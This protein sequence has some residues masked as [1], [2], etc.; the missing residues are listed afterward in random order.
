MIAP[1]ILR[2][3]KVYY[4]DDCKEVEWKWTGDGCKPAKC[5]TRF[6]RND[7]SKS[8]AFVEDP[9]WQKGQSKAIRYIKA[10]LELPA[11]DLKGKEKLNR[12]LSQPHLFAF[13]VLIKAEDDEYSVKLVK[14]KQSDFIFNDLHELKKLLHCKNIPEWIKNFP[15]SMYYQFVFLEKQDKLP[16][17]L[18]ELAEIL[19]FLPN[20]SFRQFTVNFMDR[21]KKLHT[22]EQNLSFCSAIA[23]ICIKLKELCCEEVSKR[24]ALW[25]SEL[26]QKKWKEQ[27]KWIF[28]ERFEEQ[29]KL[30][31]P[32]ILGIAE[33]LLSKM[34]QSDVGLEN[35]VYLFSALNNTIEIIMTF[36]E[37]TEDKK[38]G[39]TKFLE[40][41]ESKKWKEWQ[42][43][44]FMRTE[45]KKIAPQQEQNLLFNLA[46]KNRAP[47]EWKLERI[48]TE[49]LK[50]LQDLNPFIDATLTNEYQEL[51]ENLI[52]NESFLVGNRVLRLSPS[53]NIT[54][55]L[56][57][58]AV[59][60]QREYDS[61]NIKKPLIIYICVPKGSDPKEE[62][63]NT[64]DRY[65]L[66]D[67]WN[68]IDPLKHKNF[69]WII[70]DLSKDEES[71]SVRD[72]PQ[73]WW[74]HSKFVFI[75]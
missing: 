16:D 45:N 20:D 22:F 1:T 56:M 36:D 5:I 39:K 15:L 43:H 24:P 40:I 35:K 69:L 58:Y 51:I 6:N 38:S 63:V 21:L 42:I 23:K 3:R 12:L 72:I 11:M 61:V 9:Y 75:H 52:C 67:Y 13:N 65:L 29:R 30:Y 60:M 70:E 62:I 50:S 41:L 34:N 47:V 59:E 18:F 71:I 48:L 44:T 37:K 14:P 49:E 31:F 53:S 57:K 7:L 4:T 8:I 46:L 74:E 28:L 27:D 55:P 68:H 64:L 33:I 2:T 54:I 32:D 10:S 25:L 26:N 73:M 17:A 19:R 66:T